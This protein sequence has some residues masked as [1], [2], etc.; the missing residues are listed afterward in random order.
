M[1]LITLAETTPF[2]TPQVIVTAILGSITILIA[3][4]TGGIAWLNYHT[5]HTRLRLDLYSRR[6]EMFKAVTDYILT[7]GGGSDETKTEAIHTMIVA[8]RESRFV[9]GD[10]VND[11][12]DELSSAGLSGRLDDWY[13]KVTP[14]S[15]TGADQI[16]ARMT[17]CRTLFTPYLD[18]RFIRKL[19]VSERQ[20]RII[21]QAAKIAAQSLDPVVKITIGH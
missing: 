10:D 19:Q 14:A 9:F 17:E 21:R 18:F 7:G 1:N 12:I 3:A 20:K 8:I 16:L 5:A 2:L 4:T 13:A 11:F 6:Y 15:D